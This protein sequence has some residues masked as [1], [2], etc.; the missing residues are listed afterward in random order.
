MKKDET[1]SWS[2][3]AY[4][5]FESL[6]SAFILVPV[7]HHF[8]PKLRIILETEASDYAITAILSQVD[9]NNEICPVTFC[10]CSMQHA[11]LNY[12]I[13]DKEL[14]VVFN[15]F[16]TWHAYLEGAAHTILVIMDHKNLEY[17]TSTK[18]LTRRQAQWSEYL[19]SFNYLITY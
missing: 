19:S 3:N 1:F 14:L 15:T 11:E 17:F 8:D 7:L 4:C 18:F 5:A 6:K 2:D 16:C 12:D 13:H 10:L 9:E